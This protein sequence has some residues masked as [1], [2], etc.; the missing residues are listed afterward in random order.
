MQTRIDR[1]EGLV[2]SLM[3]SGAA[4]TENIS[5]ERGSSASG[6]LS[7]IT[8]EDHDHGSEGMMEDGDEVETVSTALGFL[9]FDGGKSYYRG[10]THWAA[11]LNEVNWL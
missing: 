9:K 1:L 3:Q 10:E 8:D 7:T 6:S 4:G 11:I 5:G 2:L